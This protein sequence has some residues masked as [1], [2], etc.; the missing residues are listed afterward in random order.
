MPASAGI[1]LN[2][3]FCQHCRDFFSFKT[4]SGLR[5]AGG[6]YRH[7]QTRT[8]VRNALD[9]CP[10][11]RLM[12]Q[13]YLCESF[14]MPDDEK[15]FAEFPSNAS[16]LIRTRSLEGDSLIDHMQ[17]EVEG[18]EE[19]TAQCRVFAE[20]GNPACRLTSLRPVETDVTAPHVVAEARRLIAECRA[21][22]PACRLEGP[23]QRPSRIVDIGAREGGPVRVCPAATAT[24]TATTATA[25]PDP[26]HQLPS[27][28]P[29]P[30]RYVA[31]SYCWGG[32]QPVKLT[33]STRGAL[34]D[35]GVALAALPPG[36]RDAVACARALGYRHLWVDALCILQ[37]DEADKVAEMG[38]MAGVYRGADVVLSAAVARSVAEGWCQGYDR[39]AAV[40]RRIGEGALCRVDVWLPA[41]DDDPDDDRGGGSG[42]N[43]D[44][45]G[46]GDGGGGVVGTLSVCTAIDARLATGRSG[47]R[48]PLNDR[49]WCLQESLLPRRLLCY[50]PHE[51]L[52]RC[53]AVDVRPTSPSAIDYAGGVEPP[54]VLSQ[55][56][57]VCAAA[58]AAVSAKKK[59]KKKEKEAPPPGPPDPGTLWHG[60]VRDYTFRQF[61][62]AADRVHGIAGI[63]DELQRRWG[64]GDQG[65][66]K[67]RCRFGLWQS[68]LL[69]EL[70]W[71][72]T[73]AT[74]RTQS[75]ARVYARGRHA[76]SWSWMSFDGPV[77]TR[78]PRVFDVL[79]ARVEEEERAPPP[80]T[81][82]G[83]N[84]DGN[85][86]RDRDRDL[87][88]RLSCHVMDG[89]CPA[90]AKIGYSPDLGTNSEEHAGRP[91]RYLYIGTTPRLAV[92]LAAVE[93]VKEG[94]EEEGAG[95]AV[96]RRVGLVEQNFFG[97]PRESWEALPRRS[98]VLR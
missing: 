70:C 51:L 3:A 47:T 68:R 59:K 76:P 53:C 2:P 77:T 65:K 96:F 45:A 4:L 24:A 64:G 52:F 6:L 82:D 42:S 61:G 79:D 72:R 15:D 16:V 1:G 20:K 88:I 21:T 81:T 37:D 34:C 13:T 63:V 56:V 89:S 78:H 18:S 29:L 49:G 97:M 86:D 38:R 12:C 30:Y 57:V 39:A 36:L 60:L 74:P 58:A 85:G 92:A 28:P 26:D 46:G 90:R 98:V 87:E 83:G 94:D 62:V 69:A 95:D 5:A 80:T 22:H 67:E 40:A 9:G 73:P 75:A 50:G 93:E 35:D 54:R 11:C 7:G 25:D 48:L 17:L 19:F 31:L 43:S 44:R 23:V 27:L 8:V 55:V 66:D 84:V 71:S 91:V 33:R 14:G 41:D 10:F 32:D